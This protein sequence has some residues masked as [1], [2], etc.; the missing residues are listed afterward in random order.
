MQNQLGTLDTVILT[1]AKVWAVACL[2]GASVWALWRLAREAGALWRWA[3][4]EEERQPTV[5]GPVKKQHRLVTN[6]IEGET[7]PSP[8]LLVEEEEEE[9]EEVGA[10]TAAV[11][12]LPPQDPYSKNETLLFGA[13]VALFVAWL[14]VHTFSGGASYLA[15]FEQQHQSSVPQTARE[16]LGPRHLL[17]DGPCSYYEPFDYRVAPKGVPVPVVSCMCVAEMER[18]LEKSIS[19]TLDAKEFAS[20]VA[21]HK[22][23]STIC[24]FEDA[25]FAALPYPREVLKTLPI[26]WKLSTPHPL[27]GYP[28]Q[29]THFMLSANTSEDADLVPYVSVLAVT[30]NTRPAKLLPALVAVEDLRASAQRWHEEMLAE[31]KRERFL[32][33]DPCL[34]AEHLGIVDSGVY[35]HYAAEGTWSVMLHP[36][37]EANLTRENERSEVEYN[38]RLGFPAFIDAAY[39]ASAAVHY[40]RVEVAYLDLE[41]LVQSPVHRGE[42]AAVL[43]RWVK[44]QVVKAEAMSPEGNT[45]QPYVA[46]LQPVPDETLTDVA[47][48]HV[49]PLTALRPSQSVAWRKRQ[50]TGAP[51]AC[52]HHCRQLST[53]ARER[54]GLDVDEN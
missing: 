49:C 34:C 52:F 53:I 50:L 40:G 30:V 41:L 43:P 54:L 15:T 4:G 32:P 22:F 26:P 38:P 17:D 39:N 9:E 21:M 6:A 13:F 1:L 24:L 48:F 28:T 46:P 45:L 5:P 3:R 8:S 19:R 27:S 44:Q 23:V 36:V 37:V 14:L 11:P 20:V 42:L 12:L 25:S 33:D 18:L 35:F 16:R 10:A 31:A 29:V 51:N 7:E 2:L 47:P